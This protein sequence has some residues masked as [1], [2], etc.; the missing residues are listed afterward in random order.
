MNLNKYRGAL[1]HPTVLLIEDNRMLQL[2]A[3]SVLERL[4]CAVKLASNSR[5]ALLSC[6]DNISFI[7]TDLDLGQG[8]LDG[9]SLFKEIRKRAPHLP[10]VAWSTSVEKSDECLREG[11]KAFIQK[12]TA[13]DVMGKLLSQYIH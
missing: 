8:S 11:M 2:Y 12:P 3:R 13:P 10:A 5:Q 1:A 6:F 7:L 4:G 9:I